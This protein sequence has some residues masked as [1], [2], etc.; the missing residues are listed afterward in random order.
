VERHQD[1][2]NRAADIRTGVTQQVRCHPLTWNCSSGSV[3]GLE[4]CFSRTGLYCFKL[5]R[6]LQAAACW[7]LAGRVNCSKELA[8]CS[9]SQKRFVRNW[10]PS[11][12]SKVWED[13][14]DVL[15]GA[16]AAEGGCR[17][18]STVSLCAAQRALL[19][20]PQGS[21]PQLLS[22]LC[23]QRERHCASEAGIISGN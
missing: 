6:R 15:E 12:S 11:K 7:S 21:Q 3:F 9:S 20:L 17:G 2:T 13:K 19:P 4:L 14:T 10:S 1:A 8:Y 16:V 5:L 22:R 18:P 23:R